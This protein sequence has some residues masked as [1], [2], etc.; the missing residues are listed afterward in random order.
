MFWKFLSVVAALGALAWAITLL[1]GGQII[2][3]GWVDGLFFLCIAVDFI[4]KG[5]WGDQQ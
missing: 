5:L 3:K 4:W 1:M 2:L